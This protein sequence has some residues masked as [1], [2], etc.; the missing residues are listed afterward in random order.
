MK[1][2]NF[3]QEEAYSAAGASVAASAAGATGASA[4]ATSTAAATTSVSVAEDPFSAWFNNAAITRLA[5]DCNN[6]RT[7]PISSFLVLMF[8]NAFNA[9]S[10][11][12]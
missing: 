1:S 2:L 3:H 5:G 11:T 12:K 9:S 4:T 7:S 8:F 6:P 10:P